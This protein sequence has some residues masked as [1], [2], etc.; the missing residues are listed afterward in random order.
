MTDYTDFV[1]F[2]KIKEKQVYYTDSL[3]IH[4]V[5]DTWYVFYLLFEFFTKFI[6]G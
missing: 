1:K 5:C 4:M 6:I 3:N 2:C